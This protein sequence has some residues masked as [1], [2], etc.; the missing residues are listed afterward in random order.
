MGWTTAVGLNLENPP[1]YLGAM[2]QSLQPRPPSAVY[3]T[4]RALEEPRRLAGGVLDF[5][6]DW[7]DLSRAWPGHAALTTIICF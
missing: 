6:V 7:V 2:N 4:S 1:G 5:K 3:C